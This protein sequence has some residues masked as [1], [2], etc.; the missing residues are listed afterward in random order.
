MRKYCGD[1]CE[2][3]AYSVYLHAGRKLMSP[4]AALHLII[5]HMLSPLSAHTYI[6]LMSILKSCCTTELSLDQR[7]AEQYIVSISL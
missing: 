3:N 4:T 7:T 5:M 1:G 6:V 2:N